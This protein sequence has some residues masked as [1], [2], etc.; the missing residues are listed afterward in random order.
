MKYPIDLLKKGFGWLTTDQPATV[1]IQAGSPWSASK[2]V[3]IQLVLLLATFCFMLSSHH[4]VSTYKGT[5]EKNATD[6]GQM[7]VET[8]E[9]KV[10]VQSARDTMLAIE[11]RSE[12]RSK[13][14]R[15][16]IEYH[17]KL[18]SAQTLMLETIYR[19]VE[20]LRK[21]RKVEVE[22]IKRMTDEQMVEHMSKIPLPKKGG[23]K[24]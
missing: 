20:E 15:A 4:T 9:L 8:K 23:T 7:Q 24:K 3:I 6:I 14:N 11:K 21:T 10:S 17:S 2:T 16:L 19:N 22:S 13:E 12:Q 18:D 1:R 5:V